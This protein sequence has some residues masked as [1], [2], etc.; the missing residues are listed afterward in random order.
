M[1][2]QKV[3]IVIINY[4]SYSET[5][6]CIESLLNIEYSNYQIILVDNCSTDNSIDQLKDWMNGNKYKLETSFPE[7]IYPISEKPLDYI[8]L[9]EEGL[10]KDIYSNRVI[11]VRAKKNKGFASGNNIAIN[12]II[13][14]RDIIAQA[15]SGTGKTGAF[16]TGVLQIL[17]NLGYKSKDNKTT[18]AIILAPTH[19]LAK[20]TKDVLEKIGRFMKITVQLLV[21]G[22]S[23]ENDK[24]N[25]TENTP[26]I[27]VGTPGRIHDM[28]RR[29]YLNANNFKVLV[30]D[31]ADEMLSSGFKEQMYKIFQFVPNN[32]QI[33][34]FSATMPND[35]QELTNKFMVDPI[36]ILVKADQ[37]T[38]QGIAQYFINIEDDV[39]K[40]ETIKDLF[41]SLSIAQAIIYCNST[42]RVDD[43][44][45][46]M[47]SDQFP[48]K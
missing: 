34:L 43:L 11:F 42:R 21:G 37:L 46:A 17:S 26:H 8:F 1:E 10:E 20:Q 35:L 19:E 36:K 31:E 45:E 15:Q 48:V 29:K 14:G 22:T 39:S 13:K 12:Y 16:T 5:I 24:K 2:K 23:V 7:L 32:M 25:L 44:C 4:N 28:L 3:Y 18:S 47:I 6:E 30:I 38:L 41:S 9:D 40:Y 33:G 27:V